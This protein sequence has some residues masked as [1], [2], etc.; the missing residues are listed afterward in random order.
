MNVKYVFEFVDVEKFNILKE[1]IE[2]SSF[3]F[4]SF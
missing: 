2:L 3:D 1:L 4:R